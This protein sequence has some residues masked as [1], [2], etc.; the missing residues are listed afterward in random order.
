MKYYIIA[1]E[2]SG[3]IYGSRLIKEILQQNPKAKIRCWG[4]D[5]MKNSGGELVMHYKDLAFMGFLEVLKNIFKILKNLSFCKKDI[6]KFKPDKLIFIDYPGFNLRIAKWAKKK[7]FNN[8]FYISPQIW[9]WKENRVKSIKRYINQMYVILPFEKEFYEKKHNYNVQYFGH[10]LV[11][12]IDE[13]LKSFN[14]K[15]KKK[16]IIAILPGSRKQEINLILDKILD[17]TNDFEEY[18]F[19]VAG[20]NHIKK[21]TYN[22]V[23]KNKNIRVVFNQTYEL[24][25][26]SKAAIVTSGTATLETALIGTPQIVCYVTNSFNMFLARLFVKINF[27]S[28]VNLIL[29]KE[30]VKELIQSDVNAKNIKSELKLILTEKEISIKKDYKNLKKLLRGENIESKIV[31]HIN[32][33]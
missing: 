17:I 32:N 13:S 4:G 6:L 8:Y 25:N 16:P 14:K 10:P 20:L 18:E 2:P 27:I 3:D 26:N 23:I 31:N 24:L 19:V 15:N 1:G 21:E 29:N 9:A 30:T 5:L 7:S 11:N 33:N 12:I 28:L 22:K